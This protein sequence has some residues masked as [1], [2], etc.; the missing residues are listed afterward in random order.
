[1]KTPVLRI[2]FDGSNHHVTDG[3][4]I[5]HTS[6]DKYECEVFRAGHKVGFRCL[7]KLQEERRNREL[8][9]EA[10]RRRQQREDESL[11]RS[12]YGSGRPAI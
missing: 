8:E 2:T 5:L 11:E 7:E 10:E 9:A 6:A 1:M 3:K 4:R 12:M